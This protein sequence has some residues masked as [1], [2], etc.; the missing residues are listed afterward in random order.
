MTVIDGKLTTVGGCDDCY[1]STNLLMSYSPGHLEW[2]EVLFPMPTKRAHPAA[3]TTRGHLIVAGGR[4]SLLTDSDDIE[5]LDTNILQW[6]IAGSLLQAVPSPQIKIHNGKIYLCDDC[7]LFSCSVEVLLNSCKPTPANGSGGGSMWTRLG[8]LPSCNTSIVI[9][10]GRLLAIGGSSDPLSRT[11][12]AAIH[13]YSCANNSWM[14]VENLPSLLAHTLT[15]VLP[16]NEM[17]VVGGEK[18]FRRVCC[19]TYFSQ[20][21]IYVH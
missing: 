2:R 11:P 5:V 16:T 10:K 19:K 21:D 12:T 15:A 7:T 6:F 3:I 13:S 18:G 9:L 8:S 20:L 1:A 17:V 4:K 14:V